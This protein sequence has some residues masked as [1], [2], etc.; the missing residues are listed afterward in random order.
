MAEARASD[1]SSLSGKI[2]IV[3]GAVGILGTEICRK[4]AG[5]GADLVVLDRDG[6]ACTAKAAELADDFDIQ[7]LGIG[8]DLSNRGQDA[9]TVEQ[10]SRHFGR[11]AQCLV[12][13]AASKSSSLEGFF[14][15]DEDYDPAIWREIM[16][17]NVEAPFFLSCAVAKPLLRAG[18][19]GSIVNI[20]SIYGHMSPDQR[21]YAGS[22]YL[23]RQISSPAVYSTSKAGVLGLTRHLAG[24]WGARGIRVNSVAPGGV[25]SGQNTTFENQYSARIPMGRMARATEIAPTIGFLLSEESSYVTGQNWLVDGGL[26]AW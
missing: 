11:P 19:A 20:A 16:A 17:V 12:N 7:A 3:T 8:A 6:D 26:S 21:I 15:A 9:V 14:K 5:L 18:L 25:M 2:V 24:L 22:Q 10:V 4:L 23:G 1:F 13:N